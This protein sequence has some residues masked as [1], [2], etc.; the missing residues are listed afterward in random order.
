MT[1][2]PRGTE[3]LVEQLAG[4]V[5]RGLDHGRRCLRRWG[6]EHGSVPVGLLALAGH[7]GGWRSGG[8]LSHHRPGRM[9]RGQ[10]VDHMAREGLLPGLYKALAGC[11]WHA[12][13]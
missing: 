2:P 3:P 1:E 9:G 7:D 11:W 13:R 5:G 6:L 4:D 12:G 10:V 8:W